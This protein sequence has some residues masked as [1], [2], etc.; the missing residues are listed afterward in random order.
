MKISRRA[1][2][3]NQSIEYFQKLTLNPYF[4]GSAVGPSD[5]VIYANQ[6]NYKNF[7]L[8]MLPEIVFSIPVAIY[9]PKNHYLVDEINAKISDFSSAGLISFWTSKY[10]NAN[11]KNVPAAGPRQI[12]VDHLAGA[13]FIF[14]AG[15]SCS[16]TCFV[17]EIIAN[18]FKRK[19]DDTKN[20]GLRADK[21]FVCVRG[22][23][24][25]IVGARKNAMDAK[26]KITGGRKNAR[27]HG[28]KN[29]VRA[30]ARLAKTFLY[31]EIIQVTFPGL[32]G[33]RIIVAARCYRPERM[34]F[35][36]GARD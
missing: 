1:L 26:S 2:A 17:V 32:A 35:F 11:F 36:R 13:L 7:T 12:T 33:A 25:K 14:I 4:K 19:D 22:T 31:S 6:Q 18:K 20:Q 10:L 34:I 29:R 3:G 28:R 15:S 27:K 16:F 24:S 21:I 30:P 8:R 23:K 9:F 5:D